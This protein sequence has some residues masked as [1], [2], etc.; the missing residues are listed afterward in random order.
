MKRTLL[1]A[2]VACA[3][4]SCTP[5]ISTDYYVINTEPA[6]AKAD[7]RFPMT[8]SVNN[9]RSP[10]RYQDQIN[11][12]TSDFKVGFYEYS[13]WVEPPS[14]MVRRTLYTMLSES[15]LFEKV[16]PSDI[17]WNPDL[18]LQITILNFDQVVEKDGDFAECALTM[19]LL[20]KDTG[21]PV[22]SKQTRVQVK[23]EKKGE[24]VASMSGAVAKAIAE[25]I[26]DME[27]SA[28]MKELAAAKKK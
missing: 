10:S 20:M 28:A 16:D 23:Q 6:M 13:R 22:W 17:A 4:I 14:E 2:I 11:Y 8:V 7:T 25:S 18:V 15:G 24:F 19:E 5:N 3:A 26:A 9:V 1:A 21:K 27:R 12:R